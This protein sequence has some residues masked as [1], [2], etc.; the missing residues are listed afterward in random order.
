MLGFRKHSNIPNDGRFS[1]HA[2]GLCFA[3]HLRECVP[4]I[5]NMCLLYEPKGGVD[6]LS[7]T[8]CI[9]ASVSITERGTSNRERHKY[10]YTILAAVS[11]TERGTQNGWE[12]DMCIVHSHVRVRVRV[13]ACASLAREHTARKNTRFGSFS[14]LSPFPDTHGM[15]TPWT[16]DS[17]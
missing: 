10:K 9:L 14:D 8:S 1:F 16:C 4:C 11:I 17:A 3:L 13:H 2:S 6:S 15:C 7:A 12:K 5:M